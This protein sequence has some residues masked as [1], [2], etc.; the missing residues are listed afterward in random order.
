VK[1]QVW[2]VLSPF[3]QEKQRYQDPDNDRIDQLDVEKQGCKR[4]GVTNWE[5]CFRTAFIAG[6]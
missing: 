2:A 5:L 3:L 6:A 1:I 4:P